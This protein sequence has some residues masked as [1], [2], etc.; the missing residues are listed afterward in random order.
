VDRVCATGAGRG[1]RLQRP[2]GEQS[3]IRA[4]LALRLAR[5]K[6]YGRKRVA[7]A[8]TMETVRR[9]YAVNATGRSGG[10]TAGEQ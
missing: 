1:N 10:P 3:L 5:V 8:D 7:D 9:V 2:A 6:R 4:V